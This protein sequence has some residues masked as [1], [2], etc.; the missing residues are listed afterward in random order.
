MPAGYPDIVIAM[1]GSM[2]PA[3]IGDTPYNDVDAICA[4][5]IWS[6]AKRLQ[7]LR[8]TLSVLP[9]MANKQSCTF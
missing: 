1:Y 6:A 2:A 8:E 5:I 7:K 9:C 4:A 3:Y